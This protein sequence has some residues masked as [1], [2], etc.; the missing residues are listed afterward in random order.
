MVKQGKHHRTRRRTRR[1]ARRRTR[2]RARRRTRRRARR[3]TRRRRR[4][5]SHRRGGADVCNSGYQGTL[6][7]VGKLNCQDLKPEP[8]A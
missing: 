3:R 8:Q 6:D 7:L 1:R 2:R 5:R 4:R